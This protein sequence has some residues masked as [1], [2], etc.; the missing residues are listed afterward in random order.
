VPSTPLPNRAQNTVATVRAW[1]IGRNP[2]QA[3]PPSER[4]A[5]EITT[6]MWGKLAERV[7]V[8]AGALRRWDVGRN[9]R[10]HVRLMP[11]PKFYDLCCAA[12]PL[13]GAVV[14]SNPL[15]AANELRYQVDHSGSA[16][17]FI[18]A[19]ARRRSRCAWLCKFDARAR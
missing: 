17:S 3:F 12:A 6:T 5:G 1:H 15:S 2:D 11:C 10:I 7:A 16:V 13:G 4:A 14:S 9:N 19:C 18:S 8:A